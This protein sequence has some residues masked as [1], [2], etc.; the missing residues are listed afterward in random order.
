MEGRRLNALD[1]FWAVLNN[2]GALSAE[3]GAKL[4]RTLAHVIEQRY[5]VDTAASPRRA[6]DRS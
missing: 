4:Q 1:L 6:I 5:S 2:A 3:V